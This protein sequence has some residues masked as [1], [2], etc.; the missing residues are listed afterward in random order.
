MRELDKTKD[1]LEFATNW[2]RV[3]MEIYQRFKWL[4]SYKEINEIAMQRIL[5]KFAREYFELEDN[6]IEKSLTCYVSQKRFVQDKDIK[7]IVPDLVHFFAENFLNGDKMKAT[8]ELNGKSAS[9]R[10]SDALNMMYFFGASTVAMVFA[11]FFLIY[12]PIEEHNIREFLQEEEEIKS[13]LPIFRLI[14]LLIYF[15]LA[16][17]ICVQIFES[18]RINYLY[19]LEIDPNNKNTQTIRNK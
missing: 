12:D 19:V 15:V 10:Q 4:S 2:R 3:F 13:T 1:Q 7:V 5:V 11:F 16:S 6:I 18:Y 14:F 8:N 9:F 17:G